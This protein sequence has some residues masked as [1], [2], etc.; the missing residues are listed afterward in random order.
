MGLSQNL[1]DTMT[2]TITI[3]D[4]L[5][6]IFE[7]LEVGVLYCDKHDTII[8][9]NKRLRDLYPHIAEK[10]V[11]GADYKELLTADLLEMKR[12]GRLV[13]TEA[14]M[15]ER[16]EARRR[17]GTTSIVEQAD[18]NWLSITES[19]TQNG[20]IVGVYT[21]VTDFVRLQRNEE[22][23]S[24]FL[25]AT[26]EA[27]NQGM[28]ACD[29]NGH[30]EV[31]N[32]RFF[33][34][35]ELPLTYASVGTP[36]ID[37]ARHL[38][39]SVDA[40]TNTAATAGEALHQLLVSPIGSEFETESPSG[41]IL[42]VA[43]RPTHDRG[44]VITCSD[45]TSRKLAEQRL[46]ASEDRY[47]RA[48]AGA[49]DGLWDWNRE[50]DQIYLSARWKGIL[51]FA[52]NDLSNDPAEWFER[53]HPD[54]AERVAAQLESHL[55]GTLPHF[56]S[57][58]RLRHQDDGFIWVLARGLGVRDENGEVIRIAGS[59]TNISDRKRVE[60]Q[61]IH[62]ALH[63]NLTG[64]ANRTLFLER[65]RQS[66]LR[67]R[68]RND[69]TFA[70]VY[71]DLDRFKVINESIGH[72]LGDDL[73]VAASKRIS[74]FLRDGD[75]IGR[76]GG[77]EFALL[78]DDV[79]NQEDAVTLAD[80]IH[81]ALSGSFQI[82]DQAIFLTASVG[83]A[84]SGFGYNRPED[85]I[86]DAEL[87]MYRAKEL[88]RQRTI[89]FETD[90][91]KSQFPPL[92]LDTDL[93][94]ALERGEMSLHYQPIVSLDTGRI[95]GFEAL[96]RWQHADRG[97]I[98]PSEFIPLAEELGLIES[99]GQWVLREAC[100]QMTTWNEGRAE[101]DKLEISVNLS[102]RQFSQVD[103]VTRI[104]EDL[105]NSGLNASHLKLEI[106][107]SAL[108][109]N[110]QLSAAMLEQLKTHNIKVCVDDFGTGYSSLSY[111][112]TF[113]IDTLKIDKSF[114]HGMSRDRSH[115]EIVRTITLLAQ[116][117]RLDVIAE[118]VETLEQL[119][120]LRAVGCGA[121]QGFLFSPPVVAEN[122]VQLLTENKVW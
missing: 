51:G 90:L 29:A 8:Y 71:M 11:A 21:E 25:R 102:S 98:D 33:D 89:P 115:L 69:A 53:V 22:Q 93:R 87:A 74:E 122:A 105:A 107:E 66:M 110:A 84:Y 27:V 81:D 59:L 50:T 111:L 109:E 57:E 16:V 9:A 17:D 76:F 78:F 106:T 20:G 4:E 14:L 54:D 23:Y 40:E 32:E 42:L 55:N 52:E 13:D 120:Q 83:V 86:R 3:D 24:S 30:L 104:V 43:S 56:E 60:E 34:L 101:E 58:H 26:L 61:A 38:A 47:S 36:L 31:W 64:L 2:D 41:R 85:I 68:R 121:A 39:K 35:F 6:S 5:E 94:L 62:D 77:D 10:L 108:M 79:E 48:A 28:C 99:L 112:H 119:A 46:Q 15:T 82:A 73:I 114:V 45:I 12:A 44:T 1:N 80:Q 116:N 67:Q 92:E 100:E 95:R 63:D 118:G 37:I 96:V 65:L 72:I 88:G 70:I 49:N 117:L 18:G 103:L 19:R 75:T 91:R 97:M 113:P 7:A